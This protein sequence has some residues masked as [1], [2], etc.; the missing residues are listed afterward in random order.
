M[1]SAVR[2]AGG[3]FL[4]VDG[5]KTALYTRPYVPRYLSAISLVLYKG[6][7]VSS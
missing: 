3:S 6:L 2:V 1:D 5:S 7:E 4:E